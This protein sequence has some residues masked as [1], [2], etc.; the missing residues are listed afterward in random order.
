MYEAKKRVCMVQYGEIGILEQCE[1]SGHTKTHAIAYK[2]G[3]VYVWYFTV[4]I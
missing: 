3:S 1:E 4:C 2:F